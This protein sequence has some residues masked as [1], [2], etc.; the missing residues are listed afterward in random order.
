LIGCASLMM[1][2]K[3]SIPARDIETRGQKIKPPLYS[4]CNTASIWR[5]SAAC[6]PGAVIFA[7]VRSVT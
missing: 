6:R 7:P 1:V 3:P 2:P 5:F 4:P